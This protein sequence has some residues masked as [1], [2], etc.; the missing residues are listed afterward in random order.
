MKFKVGDRVKGLEECVKDKKGTVVRIW[1]TGEGAEVAFDNWNRGWGQNNCH[2]NLY[3]T[4]VELLQFTKSDLQDEDVVIYRDK[5]KAIV[6]ED[7][8][9][10]R[11][12]NG[13]GTMYFDDYNDELEYKKYAKQKNRNDI[14]KVE[15]PVKYET[16]F[17]RKEEILNEAEKRYLSG[18]IKPFRDEIDFIRKEKWSDSEQYI[19]LV[20]KSSIRKTGTLP[21]FAKNTMY[22]NM[23]VD[24]DYTL[25]ELR[26]IKEC[27]VQ[28]NIRDMTQEE[29]VLDYMKRFRWNNR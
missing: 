2:R 10:F 16:V 27:D 29:R 11:S 25:E 23:E 17:E 1:S 7:K 9:R 20:N 3:N 19:V 22:R 28:M 14:V 8:T 12:V 15:R 26:F 5:T 6:T 24:R 4:Q 18:V 13:L 21:A